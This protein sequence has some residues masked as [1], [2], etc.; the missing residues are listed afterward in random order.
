MSHDHPSTLLS[1]AE[2]IARWQMTPAD[3]ARIL[4][5][6]PLDW[7][8]AMFGTDYTGSFFTLEQVEQIEASWPVGDW[9]AWV[10]QRDRFIAEYPEWG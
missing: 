7:G 10:E 6:F 4:G 5:L 1:R 3:A 2:L 8:D 9:D